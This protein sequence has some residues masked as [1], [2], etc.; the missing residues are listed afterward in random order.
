MKKL[1]ASYSSGWE[2]GSV[3]TDTK[4]VKSSPTPQEIKAFRKELRQKMTLPKVHTPEQV[5]ESKREINQK[6]ANYF[7]TWNDLPE[8]QKGEE[9]YVVYKSYWGNME[10]A[11]KPLKHP[12]KQ[13]EYTGEFI[14]RIKFAGDTYKLQVRYDLGQEGG[15]YNLQQGIP[16]G[17]WQHLDAQ[18]IRFTAHARVGK[19]Y[20]GAG[21]DGS[22]VYFWQ[23]EDGVWHHT[24]LKGLGHADKSSLF[25]IRFKN[26]GTRIFEG[27]RVRHI[28][29][30]QNEWIEE[31]VFDSVYPFRMPQFK[32]S[33]FIAEN[34]DGAMRY[35]TA[36]GTMIPEYLTKEDKTSNGELLVSSV[37][38]PNFSQGNQIIELYRFYIDPDQ[39]V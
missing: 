39:Q 28:G 8:K 16:E 1:G 9:V 13:E 24:V 25:L 19:L 10:I 3:S 4:P 34:L 20:K 17:T 27:G 15:R 14:M 29:S 18:S 35:N 33:T 7:S 30:R 21:D 11:F 36:Q 12:F 38:K 5:E 37:N 26:L 23:T 6:V 32:L 22:S 2:K 31:F